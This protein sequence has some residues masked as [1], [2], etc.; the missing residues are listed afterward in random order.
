[1]RCGAE[2]ILSLTDDSKRAKA[3]T[4]QFETTLKEMLNDSPWNFALARTTLE[5]S[6]ET[7][8]YQYTYMYELPSDCIR[9]LELE[10]K[11]EYRV[12]SGFI[13]CNKDGTIKLKYAFYNTDATKYSG[14]FVKALVLKLAE[15]IS[16]VLV[17]SASLQG[18][19]SSEAERYLR[20]ARSMNSQEGTPEPRYPVEYTAGIRR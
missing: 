7:P 16:Y 13:L 14:A 18:A 4:S 6:S 3:V 2:A 19:I 5:A 17:Q 11:I 12:E 1:M 20:K 9:V 8:L 10:D 15:D